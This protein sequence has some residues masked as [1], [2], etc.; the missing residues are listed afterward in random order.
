MHTAKQSTYRIFEYQDLGLIDYKEAWDLQKSIFDLRVKNEIKDKL[1]LLEHPHT[2]TFG[3]TADKNN[4]VGNEDYLRQNKISVYDIDRGGDI[5]YHG[6][7]QIVGYPIID[8]KEWKQDTHLYLR[9]LEEVIIRTC[10]DYGLECG[11]VPEFTGVWIE[12]RKICAIGI[13]VSRWVTMHGF[14]FNVNTNLD[15]FNGIIP[16]GIKDKE[17]TSLSKE[18]GSDVPVE[19]VKS[20]IIEHFK[21]VFNYTDYVINKTK[22]K[23]EIN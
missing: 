20:K 3:K 4:L 7:G 12:N 16:C 21:Q 23:I 22:K 17:V 1:F 13:K 8:L 19:E 6:P 5:T 9:S 2:Y 10:A 15:L 18:L 14:A 11:R